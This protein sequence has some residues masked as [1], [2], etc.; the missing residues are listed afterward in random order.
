MDKWV[1]GW[2]NVPVEKTKA[3]NLSVFPPRS[4]MSVNDRSQDFH[5]VRVG[6]RQDF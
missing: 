3:W 2:T 1:D 4:L 5:A 6:C